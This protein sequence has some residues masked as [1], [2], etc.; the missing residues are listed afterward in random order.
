[1]AI[2]SDNYPIPDGLSYLPGTQNWGESIC[3][4]PGDWL[5]AGQVYLAAAYVAGG[6][7]IVDGTPNAGAG[8]GP[9][10]AYTPV[11]MR[12]QDVHDPPAG[13]DPSKIRGLN[14]NASVT[15]TIRVDLGYLYCPWKGNV[16][17]QGGTGV[18]A[19]TKY[20][21]AYAWDQHSRQMHGW[22]RAGMEL[23]RRALVW[24]GI[25]QG[26]DGSGHL[27]LP[28]FPVDGRL[29]Q[30]MTLT[31]YGAQT[32]NSGGT[33]PIQRPAFS[34]SVWTPTP[35]VFVF[36]NG[37]GTTAINVLTGTGEAGRVPLGW[38]TRITP[39]STTANV[40]IFG[41]DL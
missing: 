28:R 31:F 10:Y 8:Y 9:H 4:E 34:T 30:T 29:R 6:D 36:D 27:K 41:I 19:M 22:W 1:M 38:W 40:V 25:L 5:Y 39:A 12:S 37:P 2:A 17:F 18:P 20:S 11:W 35:Q 3:V 23:L 16:V 21:I 14:G 24:C 32:T 26:P 13:S 15:P 33:F 7:V